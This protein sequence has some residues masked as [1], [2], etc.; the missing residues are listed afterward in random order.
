M[1]SIFSENN[2]FI[3]AYYLEGTTYQFDENPSYDSQSAPFKA[4]YT[5]GRNYYEINGVAYTSLT[6]ANFA[7]AAISFE[8]KA[9][10]A[11]LLIL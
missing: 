11:T 6:A 8:P 9:I 3:D 5:I 2:Q 7:N 4:I 10:A 1:I